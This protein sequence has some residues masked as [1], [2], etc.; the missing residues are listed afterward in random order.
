MSGL[1]ATEAPVTV[2]EGE[3]G[4]VIV[5]ETTLPSPETCDFENLTGSRAMACIMGNPKVLGT[6]VLLG[7]LALATFMLLYIPSKYQ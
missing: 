1:T 4:E 3:Q 2:V 5:G 7:I 6:M